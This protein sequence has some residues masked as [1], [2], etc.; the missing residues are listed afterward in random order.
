M[1]LEW[2]QAVV[3]AERSR[4]LARWWAAALGW[5]VTID[6]PEE[7]EIRRAPEVTPGIVFVAQGGPKREHNRLHLDFRPTDQG[8]EVERLVGLGAAILDV[9]QGDV[10]WTVL[11]DPEGNEFCVLSS[12]PGQPPGADR[13]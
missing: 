3:Q 12:R 2:E 9:G 13:S 5:V 6:S 4:E 10:T 1:D 7:M 11:G 8:A